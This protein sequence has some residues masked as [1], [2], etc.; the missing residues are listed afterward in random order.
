M[1]SKHLILWAVFVLFAT[2]NTPYGLKADT[3]EAISPFDVDTISVTS[4]NN[5]GAKTTSAEVKEDSS[6]KDEKKEE[7]KKTA[8]K[9]TVRAEALNVRTGPWQDILGVIKKGDSVSI[10][11]ELGDWY[12][13]EYNG[14]KAYIHSKWV[15]IEG[16][17]RDYPDSGVVSDCYWL[18]VRRAPGGDIL[19]EIK[20]GT[21]VEIL[22]VAGDWYKIKYNGNEAF[23]AKRYIDS[24]GTS[25]SSNNS[26][27]PSKS[28]SNSS[29][30][31]FTGTVCVNSRLNIRD[32]AWGNIVGKLNNGD[33]VNVIG[34]EGDWYKVNLNGQTRYVHSDY[35][36]KGGAASS[37]SSGSSGS[38]NGYATSAQG[39][40]LQARIVSSAR[41]LIGS[42]SFRT[43]DVDYG[44]KACAKV[45]TTAL[46][47]A[48][49]LDKVY[50]NCRDAVKALKNNGWEEV[51][52]PPFQ[53]GDVI[54]WKTYDYTGDGIKDNDTH[55]GIIVKDGNSYKAMNN[56][57]K[58]KTPRLS[59]PFSIGPVS[60]VLRKKN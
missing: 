54:T 31:N 11:G 41:S 13:V 19:T 55:I 57:S 43:A 46:K 29:S 60:R 16:V 3:K 39:G 50:L 4:T 36:N 37:P 34:K 33:K 17:K 24:S 38:S 6:K 53:E 25:G 44:N 12:E 30:E 10:T 26:T 48:G 52:V 7:A 21:K 35:I 58:L 49:A 1:K 22:G 23:V 15:D 2:I 27:T 18:N 40:S 47:N 20:A 42:T 8:K 14:K 9:G 28:D 32:G 45:A 51:S 5:D 56:S 59:D